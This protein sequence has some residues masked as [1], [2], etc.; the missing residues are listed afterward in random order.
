MND[1]DADADDVIAIPRAE[2]D[3]D[4]RRIEIPAEYGF[5]AG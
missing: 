4:K 5:R 1:P 2:F 3:P